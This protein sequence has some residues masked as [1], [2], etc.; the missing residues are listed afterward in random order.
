MDLAKTP[1]SSIA[2]AFSTTVPRFAHR[3]YTDR[4]S[5]SLFHNALDSIR[6]GIADYQSSDPGRAVSAVRNFYAGLLLLAKEVL[7]RQVPAVADPMAVLARAYKPRPDGDG[8][9]EYVPAGG[10]TID[11]TN[12]AERFRDFKLAIDAP[13]R[14]SGALIAARRAPRATPPGA[15][16]VDAV[17][18]G[19][20]GT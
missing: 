11:F 18:G 19:S 6:V 20:N 17:G 12:I 10:T 5:P 16:W 9:L 8:G 3:C 2:A 1:G 15:K 14:F 4:M 13:S 7:V